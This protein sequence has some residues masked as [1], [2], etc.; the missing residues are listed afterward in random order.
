[1]P[2]FPKKEKYNIVE[3]V[4]RWLPSARQEAVINAIP[5]EHQPIFWWL[6]YHLRRPSEACALLKEDYQDGVFTVQRGFSARQHHNRTKD[7]D[8]HEVPC[9]A[10]FEQWIEVEKTKGIISPY[11]FVNPIGKKE[12]KHY[13][14]DFLADTWNAACLK[15]G[16]TIQMYSGTKHSTASQMVNEQGYTLD[17]VQMAGDWASKES[18]KKYAKVEVSARKALLEGKVIKLVGPKSALKSGKKPQ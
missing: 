6:K 3:P 11:F 13:T 7:K 15:V 12:G 16:E 1:M 4:I 5:V 18:V 10:V 9:V 8:V 2:V 14:V 17:E